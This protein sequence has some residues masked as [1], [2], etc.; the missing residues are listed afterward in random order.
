MTKM[1]LAQGLYSEFIDSIDPTQVLSMQ[2]F[3]LRFTDFLKSK[4]TDN[5]VIDAAWDCKDEHIIA[6][7]VTPMNS[8]W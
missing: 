8:S 4:T 1:Q 6:C 7:G 2:D 3:N 5:L